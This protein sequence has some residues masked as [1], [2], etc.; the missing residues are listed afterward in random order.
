[1]YMVDGGQIPANP[2]LETLKG[3]RLSESNQRRV[4]T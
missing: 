1:M 3:R 4:P 2:T